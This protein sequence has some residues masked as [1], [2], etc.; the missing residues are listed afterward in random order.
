MFLCKTWSCTSYISR[1]HSHVACT[2]SCSNSSSSQ[3][4]EVASLCLL[5]LILSTKPM[6]WA[7]NWCAIVYFCFIL[8]CLLQL[9]KLCFLMHLLGCHAGCIEV[10]SV[11]FDLCLHPPVCVFLCSAPRPMAL[12]SCA[13]S[14]GCHHQSLMP[15]SVVTLSGKVL[16]T[17]WKG[18][19]T[20]G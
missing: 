7:W 15:L 14:A 4:G 5:A 17:V 11:I 9:V 20:S 18:M 8:I 3:T 12:R 16:W 2:L 6:S 10:W 19:T 13:P 1:W